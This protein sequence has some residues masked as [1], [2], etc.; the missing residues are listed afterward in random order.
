MTRPNCNRARIAVLSAVVLFAAT[1]V[2]FAAVLEWGPL[3]LRDPESGVKM[4]RL[5]Q[6][7]ERSANVPIVALGSSRLAE[8]LRPDLLG[9]PVPVFNFGI[10]GAGPVQ[11]RLALQRLLRLGIRPY[12]VVLEYW[13]PYL[14][15]LA[16]RREEDRIDR[17]WLD[18]SD[19]T[20]LHPYVRDPAAVQYDF[21]VS[22][23]APAYAHRF[24]MWNL[25]APVW[26]PYEQRQDFRW[27]NQSTSGWLAQSK[28]D[29]GWV[30]R[31]ERLRLSRQ[32][33]GPYLA[34]S[35]LDH[36]GERAFDDLLDDCDQ[37]G[38]QVIL[39]WLPES[40]EFRSWYR[41]EVERTARAKF[42]ALSERPN[43]RPVDARTWIADERLGDG[44]HLDAQGAAEF[45]KRLA[46]QM[47]QTR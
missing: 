33:Y 14:I 12:T 28:H 25:L 19:I 5:T 27:R 18:A 24:V 7:A 6:L 15:D 3:W 4:A 40:S 34:S 46:A 47:G 38:I 21:V 17:H 9:D 35:A 16:G 30:A 44:F 10:V 29:A 23:A 22:R 36:V 13:P 20:T 2:A 26:L 41:P 37:A 31:W 42:A 43:V 11:E 39:A 8:G 45:T 32:Y 1:Q